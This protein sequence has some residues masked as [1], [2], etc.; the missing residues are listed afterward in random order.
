[1]NTHTTQIETQL[2]QLE[3]QF[4][5]GDAG[6][7]RQHLAED[8]LMVFAK[9]TSMLTQG[10]DTPVNCWRPASAYGELLRSTSAA[11]E[12][13]DCGCHLQRQRVGVAATKSLYSALASSVYVNESGAWK[14]AL[15]QQTPDSR[16]D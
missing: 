11:A 14:L 8:S 3:K 6:F 1:M 10:R 15:H 13:L 12:R 7:Y 2:L 5:K 4:W 9:P 16:S